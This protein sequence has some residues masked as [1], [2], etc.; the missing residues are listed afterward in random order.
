MAKKTRQK[1][2]IAAVGDIHF[3]E[4][5][6][7][8]YRQQFEDISNHADVLAICGDLTQH[9]WAKE[10]VVL[11]KE[12]KYCRVP[13]IGVLG[14]HD[15]DKEEADAIREA[16]RPAMKLLDE[17]PIVLN[18]VGFAGVKGFGGGFGKNMLPSF[19]EQSIKSYVHCAV[20]EVLKLENALRQLETSKK[21]AVLHYSPI[22][23]TLVGEP[24][25]IYSFLGTSRL[26]EPIDFLGVDLVVHGHAHHGSSKGKTR[27]GIPVY[28]VALNQLTNSEK[29]YLVLEV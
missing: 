28:N 12:L 19:G 7:T 8:R 10:A 25:E 15:H 26:E 17:E 20:E 3:S 21:V 13:V 29:P 1:L 27:E 14:N 18:G 16:V 5:D 9:G 23:A 6:A 22:Q 24:P 2:R 4:S 11:A